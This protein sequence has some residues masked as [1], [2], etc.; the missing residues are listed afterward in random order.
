MGLAKLVKAT[1]VLPRV[2]TQDVVSR[3]A[4]LEWFHPIQSSSDHPNPYLDDWRYG[5]DVQGRPKRKDRL[6]H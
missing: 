3:L 2:D 6:F 5:H 4:E 1:I